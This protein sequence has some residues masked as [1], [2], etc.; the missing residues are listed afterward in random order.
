VV[1]AVERAVGERFRRVVVPRSV[2]AA[3][4]WSLRRHQL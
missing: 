4:A 2:L 3:G 1:D